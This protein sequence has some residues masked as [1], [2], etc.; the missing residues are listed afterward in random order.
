MHTLTPEF[1]AMPVGRLSGG[2]NAQP[3]SIVWN[4]NYRCGGQQALPPT[5]LQS[6]ALLDSQHC[7]PAF[8][9]LEWNWHRAAL[10]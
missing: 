9:L 3:R 5:P 4:R 1:R 2:M 6:A 7:R 8:N 10:R